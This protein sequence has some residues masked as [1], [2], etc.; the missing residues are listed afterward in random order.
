MR[1][2]ITNLL[3]G[4]ALLSAG[5][6]PKTFETEVKDILQKKYNKTQEEAE[7]GA[8]KAERDLFLKKVD[9]D[10]KETWVP[11]YD[12]VSIDERIVQHNEMKKNMDE[13]LNFKDNNTVKLVDEFQ[14]RAQLEKDEKAILF[15][16]EKYNLVALHKQFTV[17]MGILEMDNFKVNESMLIYPLAN[18]DDKLV[19]DA[20]YVQEAK[21]AGLMKP[22]DELIFFY[23]FQKEVANPAYPLSDNVNKTYWVTKQALV[24]IVSYDLDFPGDHVADYIEAFRGGEKKPAIKI[25]HSAS[26][27][28]LDV[29]VIDLDKEGERGHGVPD[30]VINVFGISKASD[31]YANGEHLAAIF[32]SKKKSVRVRPLE[33]NMDI[34][35]VKVGELK[36][37][38]W[39]YDKVN[40]YN[41]PLEYQATNGKNF[42][43]AY[44][45]STPKDTEKKEDAEMKIEWIAKRWVIP[46]S[47]QDVNGRVVSYYH[48]VP[49]Y[50]SKVANVKI[51]EQKITLSRS[52]KEDVSGPAPLFIEKEPYKVSYDHGSSRWIIEDK[53]NNSKP[54]YEARYELE[55][56]YSHEL[57][58]LGVN[59]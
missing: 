51:D 3:V 40:G 17:S 9:K 59:K 44:K 31:L 24:K 6:A 54:K 5:C 27:S 8:I 39:E 50:N 29:A 35:I 18:L 38:P 26:S 33:K 49:Q 23:K 11:N 46:N 13:L 37:D 22:F 48:V 2:T 4:A 52:E 58:E 41:V 57:D 45:L 47:A 30:A 32:E 7:V 16:L 15:N 1:K 12:S 25:F 28:S 20:K 43:L 36:S 21:K 56:P 19:F 34:Q 53:D 14:I 55:K 10:G 42:T